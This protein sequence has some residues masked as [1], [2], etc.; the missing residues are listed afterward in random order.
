[1]KLS[2]SPFFKHDGSEVE[3]AAAEYRPGCPRHARNPGRD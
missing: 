1:L 2:K 3:I